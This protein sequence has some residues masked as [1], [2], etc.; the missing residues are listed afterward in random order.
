MQQIKGGKKRGR[1]TMESRRKK[2]KHKG[3]RRKK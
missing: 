2:G 1:K 3:V